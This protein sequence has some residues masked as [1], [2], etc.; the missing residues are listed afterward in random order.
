MF[1]L[2]SPAF[3]EGAA[4]PARYTCDG[5]DLSPPLAWSGVPEGT[6]SF[7]LIVDDPDCPDP[8]APKRIWIHWIRY[9]IPGDAAELPE[10]AGNR[11]PD[12]GADVYTDADE[13]GYHGP[14]P[15]IGKHRYFFRLYALG[16][17]LQPLPPDARRREVE[18]AMEPHVLGEALLMGTCDRSGRRT[19]R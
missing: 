8:A 11:A 3:E 9:N 5:E 6:R 16:Q 18:L 14:C 15:P 19:S 2:T 7:V 13:L 17:V 12:A 1:T 10:G 4:I